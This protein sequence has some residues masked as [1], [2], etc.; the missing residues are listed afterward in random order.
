MKTI[1]LKVLEHFHAKGLYT[2]KTDKSGNINICL[3]KLSDKKYRQ[4]LQYFSELNFN[5]YN[6]E[7]Q[8]KR[9]Q[10]VREEQERF[11]QT[12]GTMK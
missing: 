9:D 1:A 5:G 7:G 2:F 11:Q 6:P 12:W 8:K 10:E 3:T 4:L